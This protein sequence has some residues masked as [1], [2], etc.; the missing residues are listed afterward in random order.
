MRLY[1]RFLLFF[2]F[3]LCI[4]KPLAFAQTGFVSGIVVNEEGKPV[5]GASV[6]ISALSRGASVDSRGQF[7]LALPSGAHEIS[8]QHINYAPVIEKVV[9]EEGRKTEIRITLKERLTTLEHVE[10][11]GDRESQIRNQVSVSKIEPRTVKD[12]PTPFGEFN[13]ILSTLPGVVGQNEFSSAYMVRGGN[14]DE[15]LVY[16]NGIPVYRPFL[17]RAGR[18]EGL[19]FVNVDL[20]ENVEFSSGGWQ[21]KYG[22]KLSSNLVI[23]YKKPTDFKASASAG[24]LGGTAHVEGQ[25]RN[26]G[27]AFAA[28]ARHKRWRYLLN[29][30]ETEG[31][32][33]PS[34]SDLQAY[35]NIDLDH[36]N[37]SRKSRSEIDLLVS[38]ARNRY[39]TI[40]ENRETTI[41][42]L[43]QGFIRLFIA[44]EGKE[45]MEYDT[46][47][48]GGKFTHSFSSAVKNELVVS[49]FKAQEREYFDVEG[50]YRLCDVDKEIGSSTFDNCISLRG[51]G[52]QY[53]HGRS[54]LEANL[55][56]VENQMSVM[57]GNAG[58]IEA[59][60]GLNHTVIDDY[61]QE[62]AFL[63]SAGYAKVDESVIAN[64][65]VSYNN[66]TGYLQHALNIRE[67]TFTYG[68]RFLLTGIGNQ[69]LASPRFQY[70]YQPQWKN[71]WI[72]KFAAGIY[73][74]PAF[75]REFRN[76]P[77]EAL[78][79]VKPQSSLHFIA[80]VDHNLKIWGRDFKFIGEAY[81]KRLSHVIPY[82]VD[83]IRIRYLPSYEAEAY[84]AGFDVRLSGEYVPG[85][86]SWL[87]IGLLT[88]R[89]DLV[90]DGNGYVRRPSDQRLTAGMFFEDHFANDPTMRMNLN[91]HFG[92]GLPFGPPG[93]VGRRTA[94]QSD[95]YERVDIGFSKMLSRN[96]PSGKVFNNLWI[97][98]E[99]LNLFAN[100][101]VASYTWI[102]DINSFQYAVPNTLSGRF[103]NLK[104]SVN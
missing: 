68:V 100:E 92:S 49:A 32:Y 78:N 53:D 47:Q 27:V 65:R 40:P 87:S 76:L 81:Y 57:T 51:V 77:G 46:W 96:K 64:R 69:F 42:N 23:R 13:K 15:N 67:H 73:R 1:K 54:R 37:N 30:L 29:T 74:Q 98:V 26:A 59:G 90:G 75:Y 21:P 9:V 4:A 18:Q 2:G 25:I 10:I 34:F 33:Q 72:F 95:F 86:E 48:A 88:T 97:A 55:V 79:T 45:I 89:E 84:A 28:A 99:I 60:V 35:F 93:R 12:L 38:Y 63:D 58:K 24:L 71:D 8:V 94:F 36:R 82:E 19:S 102:K 20:V 41:G 85:T 101:N 80:G 5:E 22:D 31:H 39:L 16:V 52:S 62:Y 11:V 50:G 70:A 56:N 44:F 7:E 3:I 6:I 66:L 43:R 91:I 17:A 61:L 14:Y 103:I 83:N 104:V